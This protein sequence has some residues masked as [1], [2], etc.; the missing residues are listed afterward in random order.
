[1]AE[2]EWTPAMIEAALKRVRSRKARMER[3]R[4]DV[5][6]DQNELYRLGREHGVTIAD[7][8]RWSGSHEQHVRNVLTGANTHQA[9]VAA[10]QAADARKAQTPG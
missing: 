9:K 5:Y 2:R 3:S 8:A 7:L 6:S 1:M 4:Q 10:Q